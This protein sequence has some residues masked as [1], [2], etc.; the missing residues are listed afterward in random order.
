MMLV[1]LFKEYVYCVGFKIVKDNGVLEVS[2]LIED[3]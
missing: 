1:Y 2:T 3:N